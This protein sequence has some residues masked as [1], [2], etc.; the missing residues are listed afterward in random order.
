MNVRVTR[1]TSRRGDEV[2]AADELAIERIRVP[3]AERLVGAEA[4]IVGLGDPALIVFGTE[5]LTARQAV[6]KQEHA[7]RADAGNQCH[8]DPLSSASKQS[9][10]LEH[11]PESPVLEQF[12]TILNLGPWF[13]W[14]YET[15]L[16]QSE[17]PFKYHANKL[18][19]AP[20]PGFWTGRMKPIR[21]RAKNLRIFRIFH[22]QCALFCVIN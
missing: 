14:S 20:V 15:N 12:I 19:Y 22:F 3:G 21:Q 8:L 5:F 13:G 2:L 17:T 18:N 1:G 4:K 11:Y 9:K 7:G 6:R 16:A 10:L